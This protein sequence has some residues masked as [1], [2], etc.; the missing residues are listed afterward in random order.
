MFATFKE[1]FL[2]LHTLPEAFEIFVDFLDLLTTALATIIL[3]RH[4]LVKIL[5]AEL[6]L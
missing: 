3:I 6:H 2:L 4:F 5:D 1:S